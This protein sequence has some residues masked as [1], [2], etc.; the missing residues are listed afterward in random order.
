MHALEN[1]QLSS[2]ELHGP[3]H[4]Q[5]N[6]NNTFYIT[7]TNDGDA[8]LSRIIPINNEIHKSNLDTTPLRTFK[9]R[10]EG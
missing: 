2:D 1:T 10:L 3:Q 9:S 8:G 4:P 6:I 7:P 5:N